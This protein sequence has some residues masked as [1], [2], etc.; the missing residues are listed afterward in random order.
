[1]SLKIEY[2]SYGWTPPWQGGPWAETAGKVRVEAWSSERPREA[3][4]SRAYFYT[5]GAFW[6]EF[7][8]LDEEQQKN[9]LLG[10]F[11]IMVIRD[12]LDPEVVH[13]EFSKIDEYREMCEQHINKEDKAGGWQATRRREGKTVFARV[14][15]CLLSCRDFDRLQIHLI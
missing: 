6:G 1:M 13:A 15:S 9:I 5:A 11:H 7:R 12:C 2:A 14:E 3:P 4:W 10:D 8:S